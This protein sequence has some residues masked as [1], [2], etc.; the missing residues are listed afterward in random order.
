MDRNSK[1]QF[2]GGRGYWADHRGDPRIS[3]ANHPQWKAHVSY[4]RLH[5]WA[6][7]QFCDPRECWLCGATGRVEM[8]CINKI[9]T[10]AEATWAALCVSC[11][12]M[13]DNH[14]FVNK[15]RERRPEVARLRAAGLSVERIADSVGA[16]MSTVGRDLRALGL[17]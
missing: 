15:W 17:P 12:G 5:K 8:A 14:P 16:S 7:Q 1:G 9:Y 10:K 6:R 13:I 11:H 3:G 2:T 4:S